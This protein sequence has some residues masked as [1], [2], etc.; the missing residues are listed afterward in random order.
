M[1]VYEALGITEVPERLLVVDGHSA[2]YRSFYAIPDLTT[3]QGEPVNALYGFV[4]TLLKVLRDHPA[5]YVAVALDTAGPTVRHEE[6]PA[7]KATRKPMPDPLARQ[8]PRVAEILEAFGIPCLAVPGYEADDVM[9]TLSWAAEREGIPALHLTGD[10]DMAQLVTDRVVLLRPGRGP[11]DWLTVL[12]REGVLERFGVPPEKIVDL[13]ALEGDPT[14]NVPGVKGI[15]DKTARELLR[16]YGSLD[17]VLAAADR[18]RNRKVAQAL[19]EHRDDALLSRELVTLREVPLPVGVADCAPK[20]VDP[21]RLRSVLEG[22]E[23]RSI[24]AELV[25]RPTAPEGDYEVVLTEDAFAALL[26]RLGEAPEFALDLETT[27]TDP[28]T[29]EIVGIAVA[30]EPDRAYYIPVGHAY[31]GA[32]AQLPLSRVLAGLRPLLEGETPRLIGQNLKY[33]LQVLASHGIEARGVAFDAMV[34]HWLLR[35]D[36]PAHG[37]DAIARD[38]LGVKVQTYKE[39]L[40]VGGEGGIQEVP[41]DRAARYSGEDAAVVCRLRPGLTARLRAAGLQELFDEVEIPLIEVLRAMERRGVLLDVD[42]LQEQGKEL[43]VLLANLRDA[44]F[45]LAGGP[46]NPNSTPQVREILYERLKLPILERRKTGPATDVFVLRKLSAHHEFPGR[47]AAYRELEKLRNTYIEKLPACVHPKTG[48]VHTSFNQTG[49]ATGRL[50]SSDPNLQSIPAQREVGVD[51]R[52]AFV[53]PPGQILLGADYSQI[54]LRILAHFSRD[55]ALIAAFERGED[56]HRR[57]ASALFDVPPDQV[58]DRMRT[59]AKRVNFGIIYG[60][61]PYGLARDLGI[62]QAEAK[63]RIARFFEAY[64]NVGPFLDGLIEEARRTGHART[65]LGRRRPLPG[66]AA[67]DRREGGAQRNAINTP[68]QGS[69]ADLMKLAMLRLHEAWRDGRLPAEMILQIHDELVFEVD[70]RDAERA[71]RVVREIME[72]VWNLAAP[73]KV[74]VKIGHNWGEI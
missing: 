9:A 61:S 29:A 56:L 62:S 45:F 67:P 46:F 70:E 54:E 42:V 36:T 32:P 8:I 40:A 53:A 55:E 41:L 28:L 18:V 73:L 6:Y 50:S 7:Y 16:E 60:I 20:P 68:I 5:R 69:A 51:I 39:L 24:L 72:G 64:P 49:T 63:G 33:D 37:L 3:S 15:G 21:E 57:T 17:G 48:R 19:A 58:D 14:D 34:A 38:E 30:V 35:P 4:R 59:V 43:E 23:F 13:L 47:L 26:R 1:N 22:L 27:S 31:A 71:A 12:D 65:L 44:L 2:L 25:L 52:R 66:L 11:A 10:K 74:D